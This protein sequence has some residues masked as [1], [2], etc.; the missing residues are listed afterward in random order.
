MNR[1]IHD[2]DVIDCEKAEKSTFM[3]EWFDECAVLSPLGSFLAFFS[4]KTIAYIVPASL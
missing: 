1:R 2:A 3:G 4:K